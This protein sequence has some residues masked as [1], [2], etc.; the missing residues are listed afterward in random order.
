MSDPLV[1]WTECTEVFRSALAPR[2]DCRDCRCRQWM[3]GWLGLA[4]SPA[5]KRECLFYKHPK[6][7][8]NTA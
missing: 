3:D 1:V 8:Y 7:K 6:V 5:L 4:K 2:I